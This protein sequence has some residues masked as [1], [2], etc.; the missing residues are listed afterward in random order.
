MN[1]RYP[2]LL[3][4]TFKGPSIWSTRLFAFVATLVTLL[5][6]TGS[7]AWAQ[8]LFEENF[9]YTPGDTLNGKGGWAAHSGVGSNPETISAP[10]LSYPS[11]ASSGIG[12]SVT[13]TTS[14][15]DVNRIFTSQTSGTVYAS[16]LINVSAVVTATGDYFFHMNG[17]P[18][19]TAFNGRVYARQSGAGYNIGLSYSTEANTFAPAVFTFR[20]TPLLVL[21]YTFV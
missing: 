13:L 11:Y 14:G 7:T 2:S 5:A 4:H 19:G 18:V 9:V 8:L 21:K 15:E 12:N 20:T 17:T 10:S 16:A 3:E 6:L 1:R